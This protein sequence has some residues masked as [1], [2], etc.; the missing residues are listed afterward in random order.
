MSLTMQGHKQSKE[1]KEKRRESCRIAWQNEELRHIQRKRAIENN[2]HGIIGTKGKPSPKKGKP[3]IGD[4]N[5]VSQS[6]KIYYASQSKRDEMALKNG[7][8][9]FQAT[10]EIGEIVFDGFNV[11][12]VCRKLGLQP[13]NVNK[14]LKGDR[15]HTMGYFFTYK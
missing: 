2:R 12:E 10:N 15:R 6:L 14:C 8:K 11:R 7:A 1:S 13:S 5:K 9:P 3:F 4:K